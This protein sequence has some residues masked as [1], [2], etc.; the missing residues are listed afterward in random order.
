MSNDTSDPRLD[1]EISTVDSLNSV[2][3]WFFAGFAR[4][5][6]TEIVEEDRKEV[7]HVSR[8]TILILPS[9]AN[10]DSRP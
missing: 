2:A 6:K 4:I 10:G 8:Q 1:E 5:K 9:R 3:E 7:Y